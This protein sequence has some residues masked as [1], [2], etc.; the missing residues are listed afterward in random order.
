MACLVFNPRRL[1][2]VLVVARVQSPYD[3][4]QA[5]QRASC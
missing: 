2:R 3:A 1:S 5:H 4:M